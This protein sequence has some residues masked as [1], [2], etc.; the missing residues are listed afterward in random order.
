MAMANTVLCMN[1]GDQ[2]TI[3]ANNS[4]LQKTILL[5]T[6]PIIEDTIKDMFNKAL[7]TCSKIA[8][9]G[10][11][12]GPNTFFLISQV[13]NT[14]QSICCQQGLKKSPEFQVFLND[15]PGNDFN[16]IFRS[17]TGFYSR[18]NEENRDMHLGLC[19][20]AGVLGSFYGRLFPEKSM[21]FINSSYSV[22][23]LSEIPVGLENNKGNIYMAKSSPPD[24]LKAYS[25]QF[26]KDFSNFL[27]LRSEE[28]IS[29]GRMLLTLVGRTVADPISKDCC[30]LWEL[31]AKSLSDLVAE[32]QIEESD[33][34]SFNMPY[35]N[36]Y[37]EEV[38]DIIQKEGSFDL[39]KLEIFK[40]NWDHEDDDSNKNFVFNKY[41]SGQNVANC[42][43]A[44][45]EPMLTNHFGE[46]VI[47]NLFT[48]YAEHV[49]EH[50]SKE[51][52]KYVNV[53]ISMI[54]K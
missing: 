31:L 10:C 33:L 2:E 28:I 46:T 24:V 13:I 48:K 5:K 4:L 54:R 32:G 6:R 29:G 9:L 18:L 27:R 36:P 14:V 26:Q 52:T 20:I 43:R 49:A 35:Y 37:K 12:S 23:W 40:V 39:D 51:K 53:V 50:L 47:D 19:F 16:T 25:E 41:R 22:H 8:D 3:Y 11:A 38:W 34:N 7:P 42:I 1:G 15:L 44:I 30:Y 17:V 21:H 45:T